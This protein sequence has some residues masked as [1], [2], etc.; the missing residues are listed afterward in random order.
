MAWNWTA[1]SKLCFV[2]TGATAPFTELIESVLSPTCLD[3]LCEGG[4]THLLVQ[5]GSAE[6]VYKQFSKL[7]SAYIQETTSSKGDLIIDGIDFNPDGLKTQFQ[8]VQR[9]K[10][11]VISHAGSGSILEAL[12]Y[13]IP[14]IVVPNTGLLDN[15]QEEL[16]VAMERN[17]YLV[18]GDVKNLAPA[19]KKSDEFRLKMSQF[20]PMTSGKHRETKSFAAIMDETT[21]YMD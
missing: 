10:G 15:H 19:I 2:T 6:D 11:L 7:A 8:L 17:N 3:S 16:A 5:Y 4:F 18:R 13:Q 21:G 20:P 12:R 1:D 9:S 14:L